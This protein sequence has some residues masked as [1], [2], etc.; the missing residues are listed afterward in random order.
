MLKGVNA[1]A[2]YRVAKFMS[3]Q[4]TGG[5]MAVRYTGQHGMRTTG[6]AAKE[7]LVKAAAARWHCSPSD[8]TAAMSRVT[9]PK[10]ETV[11]YALNKESAKQG[12]P[13]AAVERFH[14]QH[15]AVAK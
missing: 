8:C 6:A 9:G 15:S 1:A 12:T 5:S 13:V 10:G 2:W 3:L 11:V 4:I 7:M 14:R